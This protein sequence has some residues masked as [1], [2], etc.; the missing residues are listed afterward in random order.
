MNSIQL[1]LSQKI[2]SSKLLCAEFEQFLQQNNV[3]TQQRFK[4][5]TCILEALSN[6]LEHTDSRLEQIVVIL[7]CDQ[8]LIIIDLLDNSPYTP[9][10]NQVD[11]PSP[12]SLSGRGLWIIQN[13]MDQMRFQSSVAGTHLRLSLLR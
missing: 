6:V 5:I 2:W 8:E 7:H 10:D 11:C 13:W 1:N 12:F 9:I 3:P 4:V